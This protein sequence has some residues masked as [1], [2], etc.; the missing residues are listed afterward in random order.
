MQ[1][2]KPANENNYRSKTVQIHETEGKCTRPLGADFSFEF[3]Q[4]CLF[5]FFV[6]H[7]FWGFSLFALVDHRDNQTAGHG[8][9]CWTCSSMFSQ[10]TSNTINLIVNVGLRSTQPSGMNFQP[11]LRGE[12]VRGERHWKK[13]LV[14]LMDFGQNLAGICGF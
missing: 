10:A 4:D 8:V 6:L 5:L 3:L 1:K 12:H 13:D 14:D 9:F 11:T 2:K 7:H